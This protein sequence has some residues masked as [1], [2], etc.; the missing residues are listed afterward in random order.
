MSE[1][2]KSFATFSRFEEVASYLLQE[3]FRYAHTAAQYEVADI[4]FGEHLKAIEPEPGWKPPSTRTPES[5]SEFVLNRDKMVGLSDA[6]IG[7][8]AN[9][10]YSAWAE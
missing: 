7:K 10:W 6:T 4:I 1:I 9:A 2:N 8:L 3:A 5:L